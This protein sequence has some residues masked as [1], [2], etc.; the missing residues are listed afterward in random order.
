MAAILD[1]ANKLIFE[2]KQDNPTEDLQKNREDQINID[3]SSVHVDL[4]YAN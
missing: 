1:N 4:E 3:N 2:L